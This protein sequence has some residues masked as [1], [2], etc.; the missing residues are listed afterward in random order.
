M[1]VVMSASRRGTAGSVMDMAARWLRFHSHGP[2]SALV[3]RSQSQE[4]H[5]T[6]SRCRPIGVLERSRQQAYTAAGAKAERDTTT[7]R[8]LTDVSQRQRSDCKALFIVDAW[9]VE[10]VSGLLHVL[11]PTQDRVVS[12]E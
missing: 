7:S 9:Y 12:V 6:S 10:I 3:V 8:E 2:R 5:A 1:C 4:Y 11:R